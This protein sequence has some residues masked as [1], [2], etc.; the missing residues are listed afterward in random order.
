[1][2]NVATG[3]QK[4]EKGVKMEDEEALICVGTERKQEEKKWKGEAAWRRQ[5]A[6]KRV[7][8]KRKDRENIRWT[9]N[10][11]T[12]THRR[13]YTQRHYTQEPL[14]AKAFTHRLFYT[15]T[16]SHADAFRRRSLYRHKR[17]SQTTCKPPRHHRDTTIQRRPSTFRINN[18]KLSLWC[19][20]R[21]IP[22]SGLQSMHVGNILSNQWQPLLHLLLLEPVI[23]SS[24]VFPK[25]STPPW[26]CP[27]VK[28]IVEIRK[29]LQ[30]QKKTLHMYKMRL[31]AS[32]SQ[33]K[34]GIRGN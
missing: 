15:E 31:K 10:T 28:Q 7:R 26:M 13:F 22:R 4:Y 14:H 12:V 32:I 29:D 34:D 33:W 19:S 21:P 2:E 23:A 16:L 18:P 3:Y 30:N 5:G 27:L 6:R 24:A 1:M 20:L 9:S 17:L 25:T 11:N 8:D